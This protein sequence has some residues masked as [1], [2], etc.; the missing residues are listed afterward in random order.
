MY[1]SLLSDR[2]HVETVINDT[3]KRDDHCWCIGRLSAEEKARRAKQRDEFVKILDAEVRSWPSRR[4]SA[5]S[6]MRF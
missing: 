2:V 1:A 4:R 5:G 6:E 3:L